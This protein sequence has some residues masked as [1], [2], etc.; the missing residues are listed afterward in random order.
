M[1]VKRK[2]AN[3]ARAVFVE[4]F[5]RKA[6]ADFPDQCI[7]WPF[8][9]L[10]KYAYF[11]V[12]ARRVRVHRFICT[13]F[14]GSPP[15]PRLEAAHLCGRSRCINPKHIAWA[16]HAE[17]MAHTIIHGANHP[18]SRAGGARLTDEIVLEIRRSTASNAALAQ[19]YDIAASSIS[20]IRNRKAWR[21][22]QEEPCVPY[23]EVVVIE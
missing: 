11:V 22:V 15:S 6:L 23:G 17:N 16:T 4:A 5:V 12:G 18:G 14:H 20:K 10:E 19:Y 7:D 1:E 13:V 21:H 9:E 3:G 8:G 2:V